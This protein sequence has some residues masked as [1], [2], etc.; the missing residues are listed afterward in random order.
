MDQIRYGSSA[1]PIRFDFPVEWTGEDVTAVTLTIEDRDGTEL[2]AAAGLTLYTSTTLK[3]AV[4][5][6]ASTLDLAD[7]AGSLSEG[8]TVK[9]VGIE[10]SETFRIKGWDAANKIAE[11]EGHTEYVYAIGDAVHGLFGDYSLDISDTDTFT[12]GL[13][14]RF[15]W[16][17]TGSGLPVTWEA[18]IAASALDISGLRQD[19]ED[20]FPRAYNAF[21]VPHDRLD[22]MQRIAERQLASEARA[23]TPP[24]DIQRVVDQQEVLDTIMVKMAMLWALNGDEQLEDERKA[25]GEEYTAR[26]G[27]LKAQAL[28]TDDDQ[29]GVE[30]D[31][32]KASHDTPY[33]Q[34]GW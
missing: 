30:D 24:W 7:S 26:K 8:D 18:Q 17:P 22:R 32:E 16:T 4:E 34:K 13:I 14:M 5:R 12:A 20:W 21:T 1:W 3:V 9:L 19:F 10:G 15:V 2:M 31:G 6:F 28:W 11:I 33:F 29:D 27:V 23:D 25:L